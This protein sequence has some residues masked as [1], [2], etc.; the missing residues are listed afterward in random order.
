MNIVGQDDVLA[1]VYLST[2]RDGGATSSTSVRVN[3]DIPRP[4]VNHFQSQ[5]A[6]ASRRRWWQ[7]ALIAVGA[8]VVLV[9]LDAIAV[10]A[11]QRQ[12]ICAKASDPTRSGAITEY[13]PS[14]PYQPIGGAMTFGSGGNPQDSPT[15]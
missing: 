3:D 11:W 15:A 10:F 1:N 12:Q 14:D 9:R 4:G 13:C 6:V 8:V 2:S 7:T 5:A